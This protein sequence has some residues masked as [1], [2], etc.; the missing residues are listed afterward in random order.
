MLF[1]L[2]YNLIQF[3]KTTFHFESQFDFSLLLTLLIAVEV[4]INQHY[5]FSNGGKKISWLQTKQYLVRI[6]CPHGISNV[7]R[8]IITG[9]MQ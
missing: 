8:V 9:W 7:A 2:N 5:F 4:S 3:Y 6:L 1:I